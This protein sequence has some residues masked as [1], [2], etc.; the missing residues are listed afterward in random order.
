MPKFVVER[1][2]PGAGKLTPAQ[3]RE[4][5][6]NSNAVVREL[7]PEINWLHSYITD[8]KVYCVI[9]APSDEIIIEHARCLGVPADRIAKI[10]AVTDPG[11]DE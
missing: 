11:T 7:G 5:T 10:A 1:T 9:A 6:R 2:I 8:D 3:L 4:A